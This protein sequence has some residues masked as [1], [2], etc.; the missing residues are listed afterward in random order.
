[1]TKNKKRL[2]V[3]LTV[4]AVMIGGA[5]VGS[6][7]VKNNQADAEESPIC[8]HD[9][10]G[11]NRFEDYFEPILRPGKYYVDGD[12]SKYCIEVYQNNTLE[13]KSDVDK[14]VNEIKTFSN[15][16]SNQYIKSET[17]SWKGYLQYKVTTKHDYNDRI[18]ISIYNPRFKS[19]VSQPEYID[20]SNI[21][22]G[23]L[24]FKLVEEN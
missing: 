23:D 20:D 8:V 13:F 17:D 6:A 9:K 19:V 12:T 18:I 16:I 14:F 5:S 4:G 24:D 7:F 11:Y 15:N 1:M 2:A 3:M 10:L 21:K 22:L